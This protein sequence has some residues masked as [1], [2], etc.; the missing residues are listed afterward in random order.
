MVSEIYDVLYLN[1]IEKILRRRLTDK[2]LGETYVYGEFDLVV[3]R[4]HFVVEVPKYSL[5]YDLINIDNVEY[6]YCIP[7]RSIKKYKQ[8]RYLKEDFSY[9]DTMLLRHKRPTANQY[10]SGER[11]IAFLYLL[12]NTLYPS[13]E[14]K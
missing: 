9:V 3:G 10:R 11:Y 8:L 4:H 1:Q 5:P 12:E 13:E 14:M 2:E 7:Y 6:M